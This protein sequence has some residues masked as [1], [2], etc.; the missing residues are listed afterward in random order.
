MG[1]SAGRG[2]W[3]RLQRFIQPQPCPGAVPEMPGDAAVAAVPSGPGLAG[4]EQQ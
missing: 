3:L 1:D 4:P 2:G